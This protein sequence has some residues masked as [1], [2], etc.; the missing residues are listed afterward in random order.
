MHIHISKNVKTIASKL[1][2]IVHCILP[3]HRNRKYG[4]IQAWGLA[5]W[6]HSVE[7]STFI[8]L[9]LKDCLVC[10]TQN[11][12][13]ILPFCVLCGFQSMFTHLCGVFLTT[14]LVLGYVLTSLENPKMNH[15]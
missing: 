4:R 10:H 13:G 9:N 3:I 7:S 12:F 15:R 14:V 5:E 1:A 8:K 6:S 11:L 2:I